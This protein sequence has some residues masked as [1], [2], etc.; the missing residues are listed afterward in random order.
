MAILRSDE[1]RKMEEK[2]VDKKLGDLRLEL[3]K[4][5]GNI[6]I[7]GTVTSPGRVREIRKTIARILTIRNEKAKPIVQPKSAK[8]VHIQEK[9]PKKEVSKK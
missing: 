1:I 4:E 8:K 2:E 5:R 7:G 6:H 9:V 3:A